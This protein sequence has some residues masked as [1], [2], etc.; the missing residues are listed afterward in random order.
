MSASQRL[1]VR[2]EGAVRVLVNHHPERRNALSPEF[3]DGAM[4]ALAAAEQDAQVGA[5]V[6]TGAGSFFCAGGDLNSLALRREMTADERRQRLE[7]LHGLVRRLRDCGKPVIA[8]VE[9]GAAGAGLSLA[10]ACDLASK[11]F[12][13]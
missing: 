5:I 4:Q 7:L 1:F 3:F 9:G 2:H 10:L 12:I 8:A 11:N 6:L 13:D